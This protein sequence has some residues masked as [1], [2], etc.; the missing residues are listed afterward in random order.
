[1]SGP[2]VQHVHLQFDF[3]RTPSLVQSV[4]QSRSAAVAGPWA[5]FKYGFF[6]N[7]LV[8]REVL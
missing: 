1:M 6:D 4:S 8:S 7:I 2:G 3:M 5:R